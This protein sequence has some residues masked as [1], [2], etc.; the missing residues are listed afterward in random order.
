MNHKRFNRHE[1]FDDFLMG[2]HS[3]TLKRVSNWTWENLDTFHVDVYN[4]LCGIWDGYLYDD[5]LEEAKKL[6]LPIEDVRRIEDTIT[7][8]EEHILSTNSK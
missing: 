2:F 7:I 8:I 1:L 4:M 5:L 3:E 6:G